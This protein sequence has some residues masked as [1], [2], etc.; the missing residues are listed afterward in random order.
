MIAAASPSS[1]VA[2]PIASP[3]SLDE[4]RRRIAEAIRPIVDVDDVSSIDADGRVLAIDVLATG[5]QP[6]HDNAAMD[7]FALAHVEGVER[8]PVVGSAYAGHPFA[9]TVDA[10]HCVRIATGAV[11]PNGCDTIVPFEDVV[12][13]GT[14]ISIARPVRRGQHR[15]RAGEDVARGEVA[16]PR[17][18][19]LRPCDVGLAASLGVITLTVVRRP[20]VAVFSTGDELREPGRPLEPGAVYDS[21]R[22]ALI[23]SLRR[24]AVDVIDLGIVP[25]DVAALDDALGLAIGPRHAVDVIVT[26]GGVSSGDADHTRTVIARHGDVAFWRLAVKPGRPFAFGRLRGGPIGARTRN[27]W[28]F[29][30]PG[31]P[32]ASLVL[33]HALVRDALVRLSGATDEVRQTMQAVCDVGIRKPPGRTDFVRAVVHRE[34]DGWHARPSERQGSGNL[35]SMSEANGLVVLPSSQGD[36]MPGETV[37]V[38][39]MGAMP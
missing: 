4:A 25:D 33:L 39:P 18:R 7:G 10:S 6:P 23:A 1:D 8:Y 35:R 17:G 9:G 20:R 26:S 13:H 19:M 28:L 37:E 34:A 5:D 30:L 16:L 21:N 11:V 15:R 3:L 14:A 36:V 31:N 24:W 27:V 38:W 2:A 12:D 22:A 32:V 29:G